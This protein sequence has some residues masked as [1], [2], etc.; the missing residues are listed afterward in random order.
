MAPKGSAGRAPGSKRT[1]AS[2]AQPSR[3]KRS[4]SVGP[5]RRASKSD[6]LQAARQT[7]LTARAAILVLAVASVMVAVAV[8]LKIWFG[9]R[10]DIASLTAQTQQ[11]QQRLNRLNAEHKRWQDPGYV[12]AQAR[13][14]LHLALPGQKTYVVL[15]KAGHNAKA[16]SRRAQTVSL[17][18][19]WYSAFWQSVQTAGKSTSS[20]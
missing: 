2:G 13:Q 5:T 15:G 10:N 16:G 19:P 20:K 8:P 17:N 9:Q 3:T 11:T 12:E 18:G 14:R 1:T 6:D 7:T 4:R